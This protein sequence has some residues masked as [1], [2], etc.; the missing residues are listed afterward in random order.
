MIIITYDDL[1]STCRRVL[2]A[3]TTPGVQKP[4]WL[5]LCLTKEDWRFFRKEYMDTDKGINT[6]ANIFWAITCIGLIPSLTLP[7]PSTVV[8]DQPLQASTGTKHCDLWIR[9]VSF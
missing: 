5:P 1:L 3:M 2:A 8:T 9:N 6:N 7:K 4:H